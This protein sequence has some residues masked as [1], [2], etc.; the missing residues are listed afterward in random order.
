[1][2]ASLV[3]ADPDHRETSRLWQEMRLFLDREFPEAALV[4]EWGQPSQAIAAGFHMDFTIPFAMPGY[5]ALLRKPFDTSPGGDPYGFSFFEAAGHGN[6]LEFL[7]EYLHHYHATVGKGFISL[8]TGNHDV[9]PRLSEGRTIDDIE[10]VFLFLLTMPGVPFIYYGDEIGLRS[11]EL[12]SKEGGYQ[13]TGV[14]T[15]MQWSN[16]ANAGFSTAQHE[17][18]YLPID[19]SPSRPNVFEQDHDP[20]SLLNRVR[21]LVAIRKAHPAL[22]S[23][24]DLKILFAQAGKYPLVYQRTNGNDTYIVAVNPAAHVAEAEFP[25]PASAQ[26][27]TIYGI[28]GSLSFQ[29]GAFKIRLPGISGGIY[30]MT[31][32]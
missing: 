9:H 24:G 29:H 6:I 21:K 14:R 17:A 7:D 2:A 25:Y 8:I 13:R 27:E 15:P 5:T 16:E 12:P 28:Q 11:F 31:T 30:R 18:L 19:P 10:Q 1:M 4:S 3:K 20:G 23:S 32:H 26:A 22:Q